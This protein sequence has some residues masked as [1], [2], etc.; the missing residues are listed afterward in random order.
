MK[1][2]FMGTPEIAVP[3]LKYLIK[4]NDIEI[5]AVITQPDRPSGRGCRITASPVKELALSFNIPVFQPQSIK[6]DV[7]LIDILRGFEVDAFVT[8]AFG[9]ILSQ[10][11]LDIPKIGTINLH[12]SLLPKYRG[13]N[14]IQ[15][16]IINGDEVSGVTTMLT[17]AGVDTGPMLL[18]Q[19]INIVENMTSLELA[20]IIAN[21][22]AKMLYD[23]LIGLRDKTITPIPQD[24][25]QASHAPK[26]DK[27]MGRIDWNE[28]S[29]NIHNKV[30]GMKPFPSTFTYF[31][32]DV[33][34][35][36]ETKL[37]KEC[38]LAD[39]KDSV[40]GEILWTVDG[41][42]EV[43]TNDGSI[44][45]TKIQPS[46]KKEVNA[47]CWCNGVRIQKGDKFDS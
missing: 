46:C 17:E 26:V 39:C 27:Q 28:T 45:V 11:I 8:V 33:I 31:K 18:K 30:R 34:K 15:W 13:A 3:S 35:I 47:G 32:E 40:P 5:I 23:S 12:A 38:N 37:K 21:M 1:I 42:I 20:D 22:G 7:S 16:S 24:D 29:I 25:N 9:Q 36:I 4:K 44:I 10:E 14:P 41:G 19:E 2:V 6:K 43:R